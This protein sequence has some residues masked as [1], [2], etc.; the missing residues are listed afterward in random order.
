MTGID[1]DISQEI[2]RN[3][4]EK[5]LDRAFAKYIKTVIANDKEF[6]GQIDPGS[7]DYTIK[8]SKVCSGN[9]EIKN[10]NTILK[11][12]GPNNYTVE[13]PG[14][15]KVEMSIDRVSVPEVIV[16]VVPNDHQVVAMM[17]G[18]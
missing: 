5:T 18:R 9:F 15:I 10:W 3:R 4:E 13:S 7:S 17:I 2:V 11:S 14:F 12:W 6:I 1:M 8:E 16:F